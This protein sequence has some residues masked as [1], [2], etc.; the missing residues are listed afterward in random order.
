[1]PKQMNYFCKIFYIYIQKREKAL[2]K[3]NKWKSKE[4]I[5]RNEKILN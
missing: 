4:C 2:I 3:K 1:M 5:L